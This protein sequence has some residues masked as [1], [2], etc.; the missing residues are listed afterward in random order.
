MSCTVFCFVFS[1]TPN[2]FLFCLKRWYFVE[3]QLTSILFRCFFFALS[4]K[5]PTD[6]CCKES[7][8]SF[9]CPQ[10]LPE[11]SLVAFKNHCMQVMCCD[12]LGILMT[13]VVCCC[14]LALCALHI[15]APFPVPWAWKCSLT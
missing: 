3:R 2:Q 1:H 15:C 11:N 8:F 12:F 14:L 7:R 10:I 13:T 5:H 6:C 9:L 4:T